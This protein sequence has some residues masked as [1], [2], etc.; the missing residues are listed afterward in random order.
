MSFV[1]SKPFYSGTINEGIYKYYR[2]EF[3]VYGK[4]SK[5]TGTGKET[6]FIILDGIYDIRWIDFDEESKFYVVE[7]SD[8]ISSTEKTKMTYYTPKNTETKFHIKDAISRTGN[9]TTDEI[10]NYIRG[11][12]REAKTREKDEMVLISGDIHKELKLISRMPS[13]CDAMYSIMKT[14][15]KIIYAPPKGRGSRLEIK[16]YL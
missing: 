9:L 2:D 16:Y 10:R 5:P 14:K 15:D 6:D 3:K 4:I 11:I 12:L 1:S 8:E 13:V 7:I